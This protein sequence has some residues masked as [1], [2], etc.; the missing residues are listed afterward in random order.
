MR[1]ILK[2]LTIMISLGLATYG[3]ATPSHATEPASFPERVIKL[4]LDDKA[5]AVDGVPVTLSSA[6]LLLNGITMVPLRFITDSL[7]VD[8]Q[9][10]PSMRNIT[11]TSSDQRIELTIDKSTASV[12]GS[13]VLLDQ[14]P[15]VRNQATLVPVR[16]IA[17]TFDRT[18]TYD[19]DA[20]TVT[21]TGKQEQKPL[22]QKLASP[23]VDNLTTIIGEPEVTI[24]FLGGGG[25]TVTNEKV[26]SFVS[27]S[28]S[29][30]YMI[31]YGSN[32]N[33]L[34]TYTI[35][36]YDQK[37]SDGRVMNVSVAL[38]NK[39]DFQFT[40]KMNQPEKISFRDLIPKKLF[41]DEKRD[42]LYMLAVFEGR[43]VQNAF[44]EILPEVKLITYDFDTIMNSENTFFAT[45]DG[46][47]YY[48]SNDLQKA[49]YAYSNGQI[50]TQSGSLAAESLPNLVSLVQDGA[51]YLLDKTSK[52]IYRLD[53]YGKAM[54]VAKLDIGDIRGGAARG[55][56]FYLAT[57]K[58]FYRADTH[59]KVEEY[60]LL[61][62]LSYTKGLYDPVTRKH[63]AMIPG[64]EGYW[65]FPE[66]I[67]YI[68]FSNGERNA[69][70]LVLKKPVDFTVDAQGNIILY[71]ADNRIVRR[72]NV[73]QSNDTIAG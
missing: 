28:G 43:D 8:L 40:N 7:G 63:I 13:T 48:Y 10:N 34:Q 69:G 11:M 30:I 27:N 19:P 70:P 47:R 53:P 6:P 14:P 61:D 9:W 29:N 5:A 38:D 20:G 62:E 21:I 25:I 4:K 68:N 35:S 33:H 17:E 2:T 44:Y 59:G 22:P 73:F 56:F 16:F 54:E 55:D 72:I 37:K 49:V 65:D 41:Y 32:H 66:Y 64:V 15:V 26:S 36:S 39:F 24:R 67:N 3:W 45:L 58:G 18:V 50:R 46:E 42:K 51:I 57:E 52:T 71:D 12:N 23:T 31:E 1:T 60:A